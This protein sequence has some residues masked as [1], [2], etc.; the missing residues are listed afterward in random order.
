MLVADLKIEHPLIGYRHIKML[1]KILKNRLAVPMARRFFCALPNSSRLYLA[2]SSNP[3]PT[4]NF[5]TRKLLQSI[6]E[7]TKI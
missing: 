3:Q 6:T 2:N 1:F 7:S 5:F 4:S